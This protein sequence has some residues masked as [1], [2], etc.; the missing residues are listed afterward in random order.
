MYGVVSAPVREERA[1][2]SVRCC[3][4]DIVS[5]IVLVTYR[6]CVHCVIAYVRHRLA[7]CYYESHCGT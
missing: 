5:A 4:C 2:F 3:A 6:L 7:N 1:I